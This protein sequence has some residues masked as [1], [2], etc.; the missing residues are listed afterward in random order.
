MKSFLEKVLE[1]VQRKNINIE[2]AC[3]IFPN[4]R[5]SQLFKNLLLTKTNHPFFAPIIESIDSFI[6]KI[7]EL[8]EIKNSVA[9]YKLFTTY[10]FINKGKNNNAETFRSWGSTFI[11][12]TIEVEQ[13]LL[14]VQVVLEELAEINK[15]K[16]WGEINKINTET[17]YLEYK[18]D[19][20]YIA[21]LKKHF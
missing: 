10:C 1:D 14:E 20:F 11:N 13:N 17:Y 5:S 15:I 2:K 6:I 16:N 19:I 8:K 7:S 21:V 4:K 9:L 18:T 12:D 3:F